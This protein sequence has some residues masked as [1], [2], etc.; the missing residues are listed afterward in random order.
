MVLGLRVY[1]WFDIIFF[2]KKKQNKIVGYCSWWIDILLGILHGSILGPIYFNIFINHIFFFLNSLT[3]VIL[4]TAILTICQERMNKLLR[5]SLQDCKK[6]IDW[7]K[8]N[9]L[10]ANTKKFKVMFIGKMMN[11]IKSLM[12]DN[13]KLNLKQLYVFWG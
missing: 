7:F 3:Y 13:V 11:P 6:I 8:V 4:Q 1:N 9:F 5:K 10:W 12:I 2:L